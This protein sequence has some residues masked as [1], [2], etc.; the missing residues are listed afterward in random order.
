M[1]ALAEPGEKRWPAPDSDQ[2]IR[3]VKNITPTRHYT[4][5]LHQLCKL[6]PSH[7]TEKLARKYGVDQKA[8]S[9]SPWSHVV[10]LLFAQLTHA[11][12]LNDVCDTLRHHAPKLAAIR[13]A[14]P[15]CRNT[16]SHANKHRD[17]AM[18]EE[19]FWQ[20]LR[21]LQSLA[22]GFGP[23]GRYSGLPHR[24]KR[25]VHA[26]DSTTI[27][28]VANC[29]D[30]AK[31]RRRKAAAKMH[32]RLNL[33]SF[34]PA[35]AIIE[36]A[37]HHDDT[38]ALALCAGLQA[39]EIAVFDKAYVHFAN[40]FNLSSRGIF[41]VT[42]G[43]DNLRYRVVRKRLSKPEANI[44]RDDEIMLVTSKSRADYPL[45]LR[46]VEAWVEVN[47]EWVVMVFLTNNL[48]WAASSVCDLYRCRWGIEAFFKQ[49]KQ[50]FKIC[51]FLGTPST[52]SA[53]NSGPP[54]CC[55]CC[56][57]LSPSKA[58]GHTAS[59][60]CSPWCAA[61]S[62]T[63]SASLISPIS[64][65][66]HAIDTACAPV[67]NRLICRASPLDTVGQHPPVMT[68]LPAFC[69][70]TFFTNQPATRFIAQACLRSSGPMG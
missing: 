17:S 53:G 45:R 3:S 39:G 9:F 54:C 61:S 41:W 22:S 18:M 28:L 68:F 36:E 48:D 7:L 11:I 63:A 1:R 44:I 46:R 37:S 58:S 65:G 60:A 2:R 19:M 42:R 23:A 55:T 31:H 10:S 26:I 52:P 5:T 13:G 62:G 59:P 34:L 30:W 20:V 33:Q 56:C 14:V 50:T 29:M 21:H 4:N 15:P 16:L 66:Q 40:L 24:F 51:D 57:A 27:A 43:K 64:M 70:L 35:F 32:L 69:I 6:I 12:G 8:R 25:A 47:K 49:I 38:R 67:P